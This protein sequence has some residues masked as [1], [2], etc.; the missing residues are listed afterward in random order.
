MEILEIHFQNSEKNELKL[1][2]FSPQHQKS[3]GILNKVIK[4]E[5]PLNLLPI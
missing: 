1:N 2:N 5:L 3:V 4:C